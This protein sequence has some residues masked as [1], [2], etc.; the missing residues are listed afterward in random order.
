M[1][2]AAYNWVLGVMASQQNPGSKGD[3][4]AGFS[5]WDVASNSLIEY[6]L[7]APGKE[8]ASS[9]PNNN[10]AVWSG[11]SMSAPIV[12]GIAALVR[13]KYTNKNTYSSR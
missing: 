2:P 12:S 7:M 11:T 5:N 6:E 3:Y 8:I 1:Y 13:T 9:F 4:L 10:Y